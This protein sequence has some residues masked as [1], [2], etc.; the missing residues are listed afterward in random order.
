M[1]VDSVTDAMLQHLTTILAVVCTT[2]ELIAGSDT[3]G[4]V[5]SSL[6]QQSYVVTLVSI[7]SIVCIIIVIVACT[8]WCPRETAEFKVVFMVSYC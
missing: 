3:N 5:E 6:W 1:H 7:C 8:K 4:D 2:V